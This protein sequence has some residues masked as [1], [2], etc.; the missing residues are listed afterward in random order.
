[1]KNITPGPLDTYVQDVPSVGVR[2]TSP[3]PVQEVPVSA[4]V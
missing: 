4:K 3:T 2:E 1:M